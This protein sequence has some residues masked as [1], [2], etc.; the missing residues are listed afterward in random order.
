MRGGRRAVDLVK[1]FLFL[2]LLLLASATGLAVEEG[3][4]ARWFAIPNVAYDTDDGLGFGARAELALDEAAFAAEIAPRLGEI[5]TARKARLR[6]IRTRRSSPFGGRAQATASAM[7][8][9]P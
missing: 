5:E 8:I 9:S 7:S 3:R 6:A 4:G 2:P 1:R